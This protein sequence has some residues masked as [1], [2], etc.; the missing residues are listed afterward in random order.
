M[1]A[2]GFGAAMMNETDM[3]NDPE[4]NIAAVRVLNRVLRVLCRSLPMYLEEAR[5]WSAGDGQQ[6]FAALANLRADHR[7]LAQ[8]VAQTIVACGGSPDAGA[9]PTRFAAFNDVSLE[10]LL[11]EIIERLQSDI[12]FLQRELSSGPM[13][14]EAR[15]L[16]DEVLGNLQGHKE[17]LESLAAEMRRWP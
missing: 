12:E 2:H 1:I 13:A 8:R 11:R 10:Y 4:I 9:F 15:I 17:M 14:P 6:I 3:T 5:P 16:T 7:S